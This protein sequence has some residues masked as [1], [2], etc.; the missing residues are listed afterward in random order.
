MQSIDLIGTYHF[1]PISLTDKHEKQSE[2]KTTAFINFDNSEI[3]LY[4]AWFIYKR[5][6]LILNKPI[7][8]PHISFINDRLTKEQKLLYNDIKNV[9]NSKEVNIS[10]NPELIRTDG[11]HWWI[12]LDSVDVDDIRKEC[13]L[14]DIYFPYHITIGYVNNK[15]LEHSKYIHRQIL[16]YNL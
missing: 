4:Y 1:D 10:Y 15:N 2:W 11:K 9:Y 5:F 7:R 13:Q 6:N 8:D 12:K 3:H 14:N 16:K